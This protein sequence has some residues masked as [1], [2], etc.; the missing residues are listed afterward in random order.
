MSQGLDAFIIPE[1]W[2]ELGMSPF[3]WPHF[4]FA[5]DEAP[6]TSSG[7][8]WIEY[9]PER[10]NGERR[11][12][13]SHNGWND[14]KGML[15]GMNRWAHVLITIIAR[16]L[17]HG[18]Y[19]G[20]SRLEEGRQRVREWCKTID[21]QSDPLLQSV[22]EDLLDSYGM[23]DRL[24]EDGIAE[25]I[26]LRFLNDPVW[27]YAGEYISL[28]RFMSYVRRSKH[29]DKSWTKMHIATFLMNL[30]SGVYRD[31][32]LRKNKAKQ[33]KEASLSYIRSHTDMLQ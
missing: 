19:H 16:N 31:T 25:Y 6:D 7:G 22:I 2:R 14:I 5:V 23:S 24:A 21:P 20:K 27:E 12:D 17:W 32:A 29:D 10:I 4:S 8:N 3:S 18:P 30:H 28:N 1:N 11:L 33:A 26:V 15:R 9:G 13:P